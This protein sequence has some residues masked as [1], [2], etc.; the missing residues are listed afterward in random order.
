MPALILTMLMATTSGA[1][2][3]VATLRT[4]GPDA[5]ASA[6][7][8]EEVEG[9]EAILQFVACL[10]DNGIDLPDPQFG[11][12][13]GFFGGGESQLA[14]IDFMSPDFLAAMEACQSLLDAL[15]P[16]ID[17]EQQAE[18]NEEMLEFAECMRAEG[19]EDFPDP[20]PIRGLTLGS[21]RG[22]NGGLAFDPFSPEFLAASSVCV[23]QSGLEVPG[24]A[25]GS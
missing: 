14:G 25:A 12:E 16:E 20:D 10:R 3:Q 18:Q 19:I 15:R 17:P 11:L 6:A 23:A 7:P 2:A 9:Q 4:P 8:V 21:M 1:A 5:E 22:E 13:G 24:V